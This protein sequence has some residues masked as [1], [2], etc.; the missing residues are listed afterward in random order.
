MHGNF[1]KPLLGFMPTWAWCSYRFHTENCKVLALQSS[2]SQIC[3]LICPKIQKHSWGATEQ[4]LSPGQS[5]ERRNR[6]ADDPGAIQNMMNTEREV[7]GPCE[8]GLPSSLL[9]QPRTP[10]ALLKAAL[11]MRGRRPRDGHVG[12]CWYPI[13]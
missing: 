4:P 1:K 10:S 9:S 13:Q 3:L 5:G 12:V 2:S 11:Q 8:L 6:G 7:G